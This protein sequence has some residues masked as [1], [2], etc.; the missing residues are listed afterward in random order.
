VSGRLAP[1]LLAAPLGLAGA[2]GAGE[3]PPSF[4][5]EIEV[6]SAG[7]AAVRLDRDVYEAARADLGDLRVLDGRGR[8]VA[9]VIDRG[10]LGAPFVEVRPEVRNRGFRPDGAA[11]A[12]LDFGRRLAKHRLELRLSGDNFRRRATVEG[13]DGAEWTTLVEDAWVF[14]VPGK[15]P[16]RYETVDLP[17]NDFSRLRVVVHPSPDEKERPAIEDAWVPGERRPPR[18]FETWAPRWSAA[19]DAK[20]RETWLTLDLGARHQPSAPVALAAGCASPDVRAEARRETRQTRADVRQEIGRRSGSTGTGPGASPG[21]RS[22][23]RRPP[24]R[25]Q[26]R[27][28]AADVAVTVHAR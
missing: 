26:P 16:F 24:A 14:A 7:R 2:G 8:E 3:A 12:V 13:G 22:R 11:T 5:R 20:S 27:R 9:Y 19:R 23:A 21:E 1:L 15:E 4:E 6:A 18:R 10:D 17:E 28:P 25:P